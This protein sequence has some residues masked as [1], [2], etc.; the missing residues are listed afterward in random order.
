MDNKKIDRIAYTDAETY[1]WQKTDY[2]DKNG[3]IIDEY[4]YSKLQW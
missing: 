1:V 2:F 4:F 3:K